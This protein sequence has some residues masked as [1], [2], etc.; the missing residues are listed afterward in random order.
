[1]YYIVFVE[2]GWSIVCYSFCF[3][4]SGQIEKK[5]TSV[6]LNL[7]DNIMNWLPMITCNAILWQTLSGSSSSKD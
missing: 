3:V 6:R 5:S 4:I 2:S 7:I 1:M